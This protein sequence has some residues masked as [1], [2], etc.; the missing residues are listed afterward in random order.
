MSPK[1][2]L[3]LRHSVQNFQCLLTGLSRKFLLF[4]VAT[5]CFK[6]CLLIGALIYHSFFLQQLRKFLQ[7]SCKEQILCAN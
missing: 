3:F 5:S 2:L 6:V 1:V 4:T 7:P